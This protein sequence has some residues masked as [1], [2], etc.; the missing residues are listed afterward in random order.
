M[1]K[2]FTPQY[3]SQNSQACS[4]QELMRGFHSSSILRQ[5]GERIQMIIIYYMDK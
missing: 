5:K 2:E 4:L 3:T 1:I